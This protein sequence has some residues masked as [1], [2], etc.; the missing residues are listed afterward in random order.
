MWMQSAIKQAIKGLAK[1]G[2]DGLVFSVVTLGTFSALVAHADPAWTVGAGCG[3]CLLW[4]LRN[5]LSAWLLVRTK[6]AE[7]QLKAQNQAL[8]IAKK[9]GIPSVPLPTPAPPQAPPLLSA[10]P[11]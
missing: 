5:F 9:F 10:P 6:R 2:P 1:F 7:L 3:F 8:S 11:K 4:L